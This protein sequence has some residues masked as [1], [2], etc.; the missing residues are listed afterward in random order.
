MDA[1]FSV[2]YSPRCLNSFA[3]AQISSLKKLNAVLHSHSMRKTNKISNELTTTIISYQWLPKTFHDLCH[4]QQ[5]S[6]FLT[7]ADSVYTRH[8]PLFKLYLICTI[9]TVGYAYTFGCLVVIK[10]ADIRV[11]F[12]TVASNLK[13]YNNNNKR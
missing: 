11:R 10:L 7:I 13:K 1:V 6:T 3:V 2:R 9:S 8:C 4:S 5:Y 12:P